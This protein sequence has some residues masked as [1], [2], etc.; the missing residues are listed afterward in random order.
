SIRSTDDLK[1]LKLRSIQYIKMDNI[2]DYSFLNKAMTVAGNYSDGDLQPVTP[3]W[4]SNWLKDELIFFG[5]NQVDTAYYYN[6]SNFQWSNDIEKVWNEGVGI[7]NYRGWGDAKGWKYPAFRNVNID[8]TEG[9]LNNGWRLPV[10]LSF[11]CNTGDFGNLGVVS[12]FGEKMVTAGS[13]NNPRGAAAMVGP[14]DLDTDTRFNN[15]LCAVMWDELLEGRIPELAPALHAGKQAINTEFHNLEVNGTNISEFYHHVYGVLGDPSLPV[16]LGEPKNLY[17]EVADNT[18]L[19]NSHIS[20]IITDSEGNP[21]MDVVGALLANDI[22]I[23]KGLSNQHG[24]LVIDFSGV[25]ENTNL[26]LYLNKAQFLQKKI[27]LNFATDE[28][29]SVQTDYTIPD[30]PSPP[31]YIAI[32]SKSGHTAAPQYNWIDISE[33]GENLGLTD[34]SVLPDLDIG[35]NFSFYNEVF[36]KITVC[37]NG[38]ASFLPCLSSDGTGKDCTTIPYFFNNS[39]SHPAGPRGMLAPFFD[40]LDDNQGKEEFNVF[41]W[42][43]N[44]DSLIIQWDN[45][46]N[47]Q[48]D[49]NCIIGDEDSCPRHTFQLLLQATEAGNGD[50]IFQYYNVTNWKNAGN[51]P[52]FLWHVDDHGATVGIEAPDKNSGT[53]YLFYDEYQNASGIQNNLA[54]RF[55]PNCQGGADPVSGF[56]CAGNCI[57][58]TDCKGIC[59]GTTQTDECGVCGGLGAVYECGCADIP[60]GA[61]DCDENTLDCNGVCGGSDESCLSIENEFVPEQISISAYPNPFNPELTIGV[62]IPLLQHT[63]ISVIDL[64]G[65]NLEKIFEGN[66]SPG[67]HTFSWEAGGY[68]SGVYLISVNSGPLTQTQKV[69][70]LK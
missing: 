26:E 64:T 61:C 20:T 36:N 69:L 39:I 43:N 11:V 66:I 8:G 40:D 56:D 9:N 12:C 18:T 53:E 70:L 41:F 67:A 33:K 34:D 35:F 63:L 23:A 52:T 31:V 30:K 55:I 13:L 10:V 19:T 7:I 25:A 46:A 29:A 49:E 65:R 58:N 50:I 2:Q 62:N 4:T 1:K 14:S 42:S 37:S 51:D 54:I 5:F 59:G 16:W 32:D 17:S 57:T 44:T 47:G 38:W 48:H 22:L 60:V 21:V 28:G 45:V 68:P 24:E 3:V 15:V 27:A 6:E